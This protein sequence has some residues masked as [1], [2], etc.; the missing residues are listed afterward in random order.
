MANGVSKCREER[1]S[2]ECNSLSNLQR[3]NVHVDEIPKCR[4]NIQCFP[5]GA[6]FQRA[7]A[8]APPC[9]LVQDQRDWRQLALNAPAPPTAMQLAPPSPPLADVLRPVTRND[10]RDGVSSHPRLL[11]VPFPRHH[12]PRFVKAAY[13]SRPC[14]TSTPAALATPEGRSATPQPDSK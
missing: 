3:S 10:R 4:L 6:R 7:A 9:P 2:R 13:M 12:E 8:C 14:G 11:G 5:R 1:L